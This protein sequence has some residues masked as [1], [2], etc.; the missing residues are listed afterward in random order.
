MMKL[1]I[2]DFFFVLQD[3]E[4]FL[5]SGIL[6]QTGRFRNI[7]AGIQHR[8]ML[9]PAQ[10]KFNVEIFGSTI[11]G[12]P[13]LGINRPESMKLNGVFPLH[14]RNPKIPVPKFQGANQ[15]TGSGGRSISDRKSH[16]V[17]GFM[18]IHFI[19]DWQQTGK[20]MDIIPIVEEDLLPAFRVL[21]PQVV[22]IQFDAF[23]SCNFILSISEK[24]KKIFNGLLLQIREETAQVGMTVQ[25]QV[26]V[27]VIGQGFWKGYPVMGSPLHQKGKVKGLAVIGQ[28]HVKILQPA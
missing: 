25:N 1:L 23:S 3:Q 27:Q 9:N 11:K 18:E 5:Q 17:H 24:P 13:I 6:F 14:S 26:Q 4:A 2:M 15:E 21:G 20:L 7:L 19:Y 16:V 8:I 28:D 10:G 22:V 12:S